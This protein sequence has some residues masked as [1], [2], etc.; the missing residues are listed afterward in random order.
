MSLY[1]TEDLH[2]VGNLTIRVRIWH[3]DAIGMAAEPLAFQQDDVWY[4]VGINGF[5]DTMVE[6]FVRDEYDEST[7]DYIRDTDPAFEG[8]PYDDLPVSQQ[9]YQDIRI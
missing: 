1:E 9:E 6:S 5:A 4:I 3:D 7:L 2:S 8:L